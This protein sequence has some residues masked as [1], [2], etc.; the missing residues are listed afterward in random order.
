MLAEFTHESDI[1]FIIFA[2]P[3]TIEKDVCGN[4]FSGYI[5]ERT[6]VTLSALK[7]FTHL[8]GLCGEL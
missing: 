1:S 2:T 8:P 3:T 4:A 6:P 7:T 5:G